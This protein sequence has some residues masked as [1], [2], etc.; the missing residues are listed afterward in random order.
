MSVMGVV[1]LFG[2]SVVVF[3]SLIRPEFDLIQQTRGRRAA[4]LQALERARTVGQVIGNLRTAYESM[5]EFQQSVSNSLPN[6]EAVPLF[7]NQIQGLAG[8]NKL[9]LN[10]ISFQPQ[11]VEPSADKIVWPTKTIRV[12]I[13]AEGRYQNLKE[14]LRDVETN[15]RLTDVRSLKLRSVQSRPD[16][17]TFDAV[18][19][20]YYQTAEGGL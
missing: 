11:T 9:A 3:T 5:T 12:T 7:L 10:S 17:F 19:D 2:A 16:I 20:T 13:Q 1:L 18:V 8:L 14:F 15:I 4:G 6:G